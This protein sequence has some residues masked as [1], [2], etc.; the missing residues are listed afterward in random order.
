MESRVFQIG[1]NRCGTKALQQLFVA[2]GYRAA[3]WQGGQLAAAIEVARRRSE[4]LLSRAGEYDLY[5]DME[6]RGIPELRTRWFPKRIFRALLKELAVDDAWAPIYAYKYFAELDV[7]YPGSKFVLNTRNID[8]WLRSR[9]QFK[10]DYRACVHG[11]DAHEGVGELVACWEA[12]WHAHH[13]TVR[14]YFAGRSKDLLV[15][16]IETDPIEKLV[17]FVAPAPLD[18]AHWRVHNASGGR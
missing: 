15:F 12:D 2:N 4:P 6:L 17:A 10:D 14:E 8:H 18:P 13:R 9:L 11:D 1:L 16:D 3:H 5:T 7:Q